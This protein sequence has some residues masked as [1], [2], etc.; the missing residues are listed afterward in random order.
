MTLPINEAGALLMWRRE[1]ERR[2]RKV[3]DSDALHYAA[4]LEARAREEVTEG[5]V[6]AANEDRLEAATM[7]VQYLAEAQAA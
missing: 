1:V 4:C 7:L 5:L 3:T 6:N 2:E